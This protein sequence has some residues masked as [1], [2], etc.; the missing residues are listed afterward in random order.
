MVLV[1]LSKVGEFRAFEEVDVLYALECKLLWIKPCRASGWG[2]DAM[3]LG[4]V[5]TCY[6]ETASNSCK[7]RHGLLLL[8]ECVQVHFSVME[9]DSFSPSSKWETDNSIHSIKRGDTGSQRKVNAPELLILGSQT[10]RNMS[11]RPKPL[12]RP[13]PQPQK[14]LDKQRQQKLLLLI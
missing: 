8:Q 12:D 9:K 7:I 11:D 1:I 13:K 14:P 2:G 10:I 6:M 5:A 3:A 4:D